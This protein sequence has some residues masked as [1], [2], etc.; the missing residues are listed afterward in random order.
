MNTSQTK[1]NAK[2]SSQ[3]EAKIAKSGNMRQKL[4]TQFES[5]PLENETFRPILSAG[6]SETAGKINPKIV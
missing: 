3:L 5:I 2:N 6:S 1:V 4:P